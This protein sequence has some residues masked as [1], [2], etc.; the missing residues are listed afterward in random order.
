MNHDFEIINDTP[1]TKALV[2]PQS[3]KSES[4]KGSEEE[5]ESFSENKVLAANPA[6]AHGIKSS[7]SI[8]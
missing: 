4:R 5:K 7:Y 3:T 6:P 2:K 8:W 1:A